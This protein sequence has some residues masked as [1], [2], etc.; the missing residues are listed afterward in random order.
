MLRTSEKKLRLFWLIILGMDFFFLLSTGSRTGLVLIVIG[1]GI[2]YMD[3][4][5]FNRMLYLGVFSFVLFVGLYIYDQANIGLQQDFSYADGSESLID[6][7][8]L[9][10][11]ENTRSHVWRAQ[12]RG[13]VNNPIFGTPLWGGRMGFGENSWLAVAASLGI[14]GFV[15][16]LIMGG[17]LLS[18]CQDLYFRWKVKR[19]LKYQVVLATLL[20]LLAGSI[21]EAYLLATLSFPLFVLLFFTSAG[22]FLLKEDQV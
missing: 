7:R 12:W 3:K 13:F 5:T 18:M 21:L 16:M 9:A 4:I 14:I 20:C 17:L 15:P 6:T 10:S 11:T 8:R 19:D 22:D 1:V 2:M